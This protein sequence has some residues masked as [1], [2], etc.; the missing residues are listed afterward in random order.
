MRAW[1]FVLGLALATPAAAQTTPPQVVFVEQKSPVAAG[2]F[3][4][5]IPGAG[6]AY[7][8]QWGKGVVFLTGIVGSFALAGDMWRNQE[9]ECDA[10]GDPFCENHAGEWLAIVGAGLYVWNVIDAPVT[11][12]RMNAA[13]RA[14]VQPTVSTDGRVGLAVSV[15]WR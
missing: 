8:G 13:A 2:I 7:N 4:M 10:A 5:L 11:A 6:Q 15:P 1:V 3:S 14:R 12:S 9:A